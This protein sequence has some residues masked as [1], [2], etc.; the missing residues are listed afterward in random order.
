MYQL[1]V[2]RASE[3]SKGSSLLVCYEEDELVC[4]CEFEVHGGLP[5][6]VK[7]SC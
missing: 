4:S 2:V 3:Q 1:E 5:V 7:G 6:V